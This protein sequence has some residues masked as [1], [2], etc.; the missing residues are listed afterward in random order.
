MPRER[1][2]ALELRALPF[3]GG[4]SRTTRA[5]QARSAVATLHRT[6]FARVEL[7]LAPTCGEQAVSLVDQLSQMS[8]SLIGREFPVYSRAEMPV[9][10]SAACEVLE[11]AG[12]GIA[13]TG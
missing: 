7:D 2:P 11:Y 8:W 12:R 1:R 3:S 4:L 13:G 9:A 10:P 5:A 6:R